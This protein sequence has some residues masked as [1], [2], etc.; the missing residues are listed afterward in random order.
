MSNY[1]KKLR[2]YVKEYKIEKNV[3]FVN[4]REVAIWAYKNKKWVPDDSLPIQKL[5]KDLGNALRE[6]RHTD[7]RGRKVRTNHVVMKNEN[8]K[9]IPIWSDLQK[10]SHKHMQLSFVQ[11]RK[12]II[13]NCSQLKFDMDS[14]NENYNT[15]GNIQLSFNFIDDIIELEIEKGIYKPTPRQRVKPNIKLPNPVPVNPSHVVR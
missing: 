13:G 11:R 5:T 3:D 9:Q 12:R 10:A 8:G 2:D 15:K 6:E 14:Y 7:A 1:N 4:T